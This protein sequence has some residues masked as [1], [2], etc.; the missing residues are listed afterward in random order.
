MHQIRFRLGIRPDPAGGAYSAS[1]DSQSEFKGP[2]SKGGE[3]N[4]DPAS[5]LDHFK[6]CCQDSSN[7]IVT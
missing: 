6:H 7:V 3:E 2:T 5:F 1:P 4:G